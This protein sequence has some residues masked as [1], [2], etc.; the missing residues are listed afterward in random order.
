MQI[1]RPKRPVRPVGDGE[2]TQL[3]IDVAPNAEPEDAR[4]ARWYIDRLI[5]Q[6]EQELHDE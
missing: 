1:Y 3:D 4:K 5:K 6:L 2:A